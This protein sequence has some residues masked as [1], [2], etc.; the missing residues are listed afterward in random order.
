MQ[1]PTKPPDRV[2]LF[3]GPTL[4]IIREFPDEVRREVGYALDFAERGIK[5]PSAK[6]LTG[7]KS[8]KGA[9]VLEIAEDDDG[10]TYRAVYT[11]KFGGAVYVLHAFQKKSTKGIATPRKEIETIKS[12]LIDAARHYERYVKQR[13]TA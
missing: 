3:M 12:R 5:H 10:N 13:D 7:E 6:P 1:A 11:V 8:F 9:S 2:I 4:R